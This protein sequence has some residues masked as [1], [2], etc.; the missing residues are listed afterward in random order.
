MNDLDLRDFFDAFDRGDPMML[1]A[2]SEL[3]AEIRRVAPELLAKDANWFRTWTWGG[4]RDLLTGLLERNGKFIS[5][6]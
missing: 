3:Q 6:S 2:I 5:P 4:K 1:A